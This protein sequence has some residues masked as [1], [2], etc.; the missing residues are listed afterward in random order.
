MPEVFEVCPELIRLSPMLMV[1][2]S[3]LTGSGVLIYERWP[4][5]ATLPPPQAAAA[6]VQ[7][8]SADARLSGSSARV[9]GKERIG[10]TLPLHFFSCK[11]FCF[12]GN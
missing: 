8:S 12:R 6:A 1:N 2:W 4:D 5:P 11:K 7:V 9:S 10:S 3:T